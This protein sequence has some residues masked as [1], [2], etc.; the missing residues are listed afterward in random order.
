[1]KVDG[2]TLSGGK[3]LNLAP[4]SYVVKA[5]AA[6]GRGNADGCSKVTNAVV[7]SQPLEISVSASGTN[8][9][10]FGVADGYLTVTASNYNKL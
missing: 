1:V 9:S 6:D 10:C 2:A 3:F 4:G 5:L 8:V 7:I